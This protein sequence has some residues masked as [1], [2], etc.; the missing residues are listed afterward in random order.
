M[1]TRGSLFL[2]DLGKVSILLNKHNDL[3]EKFTHLFNEVFLFSILKK[4]TT[5][6]VLNILKTCT[7]IRGN[8]EWFQI[9]F[10]SIATVWFGLETQFSQLI[11]SQW[12]PV[13]ALLSHCLVIA[14]EGKCL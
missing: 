2:D 10:S 13:N 3:E 11:K 9:M 8:F 4:N 1:H 7:V 6:Q 5:S 12:Y 14:F